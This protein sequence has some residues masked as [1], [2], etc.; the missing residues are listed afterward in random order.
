MPPYP[1]DDADDDAE[2][3][4]GLSNPLWPRIRVI[5]VDSLRALGLLP[6]RVDRPVVGRKAYV[7]WWERIR[8]LVVLAAIVTGLGVA[9][10][11]VIGATLVVM[12]TFLE[13]AV[14]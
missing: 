11:V 5:A 1:G 4:F 9:L 13:Q 12:G 2:L 8:A 7:R 10:A 6:R 3:V 14:S